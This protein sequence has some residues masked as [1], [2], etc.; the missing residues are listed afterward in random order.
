MK[1]TWLNADM[2][3]LAEEYDPGAA[4]QCREC[5]NIQ[6]GREAALACPECS[7]TRFRDIVIKEEMVRLAEGA[8]CK[9]VIVPNSEF[10]ISNGGVGCLTR[11]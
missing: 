11:Y 6:I 4:W 2:L 10:L 8:S 9:V 7:G 5:S 1:R 3:F